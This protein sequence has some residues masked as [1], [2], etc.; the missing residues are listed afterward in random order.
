[1]L[2]QRQHLFSWLLLAMFFFTHYFVRVSPPLM[3]I[4]LMRQFSIS[5]SHIGLISSLYF[6][7]YTFSQ[8][9]A[10][11]LIKKYPIRNLIGAASFGCAIA[12]LLFSLSP[13]FPFA[14]L[15][16]M[17]YAFF[18]SF[19]FIGVISYATQYIPTYGSFLIGM[20]KSMGMAAGFIATNWITAQLGIQSW[21]EIIQYFAMSL[22]ALGMIIFIFIPVFEPKETASTLENSTARA[23]TSNAFI[24]YN[25]QT[26]TNSLYAGLIYAPTMIFTES[27]LG[28]S[29][30][31]SIH[32]H[33]RKDIAFAI[34]MIFIAW[35]IGAPLC[36]LVSSKYGRSRVM[37]FS[38]IAGLVTAGSVIFI[39][40]SPTHL[41]ICL[42]LFGMT[43]TG[44]IGCYSI[45]SEMHGPKNASVSLAI[46]NMATILTG[47]I[48][49][50]ILSF[51]LT[52][53]SSPRFIDGIPCYSSVDY[54]RVF[55]T[56]MIATAIFSYIFSSLTKE[57]SDAL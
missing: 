9:P 3:S 35:M 45:A 43:N 44:L 15:S 36:G 18:G 30:L 16:L 46:A 49:G 1:M 42:F 11:Y 22:A 37:R 21:Q 14:L 39:P 51:T 31:E 12:A 8:I 27:G 32:Q 25:V 5:I 57:P 54:Q 28:P 7:I 52:F 24:Y 10:G 6:L 29:L 50:G 4:E 2:T 40:M 17:L 26:W 34:S 19:G 23:S 56:A 38:A 55:G 47:S 13:S 53:T 41:A 20:T 33:S 48:L